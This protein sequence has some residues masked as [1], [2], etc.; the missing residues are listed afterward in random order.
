MAP[1]KNC[2]YDM[3]FQH[4]LAMDGAI[5]VVPSLVHTRYRWSLTAAVATHLLLHCNPPKAEMIA[6]RGGFG[7]V[8]SV[9]L[10]A[11]HKYLSFVMT[12]RPLGTGGHSQPRAAEATKV[13]GPTKAQQVATVR[14]RVTARAHPG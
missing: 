5:R 12:A 14:L 11:A 4:F 8:T 7:S 1:D 13:P 10:N 9:H 2:L 3:V 6:K